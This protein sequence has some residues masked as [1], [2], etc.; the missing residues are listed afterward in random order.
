MPFVSKLTPDQWADA[1][2]LRASGELYRT[3]ARR[4]GLNPS[5]ISKRARKEGWQPPIAGQSSLPVR[6]ANDALARAADARRR[7]VLRLLAVIDLRIRM[8]ELRMERRL[9]GPGTDP[10]ALSPTDDGDTIASLIDSINQVAALDRTA[11]PTGG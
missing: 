5:A 8:L 7:L 3:I 10:A 1:R 11:S 2:R 9:M 6:T 4:F